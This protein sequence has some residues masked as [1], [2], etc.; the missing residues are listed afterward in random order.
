MP[1]DKNKSFFFALGTKSNPLQDVSHA[2]VNLTFYQ[3]S[4]S[5]LTL[6]DYLVGDR[7]AVADDEDAEGREDKGY[8]AIVEQGHVCAGEH[9]D[10]TVDYRG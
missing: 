7:F 10:D 2:G 1:K 9:T 4:F 6:F 3:S 8:R 5:S